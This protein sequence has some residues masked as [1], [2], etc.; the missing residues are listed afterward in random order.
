MICYVCSS[1]PLFLETKFGSI[2]QGTFCMCIMYWTY[3]LVT[4]CYVCACACAFVD[5]EKIQMSYFSISFS[6]SL[7][8]FFQLLFYYFGSTFPLSWRTMLLCAFWTDRSATILCIRKNEFKNDNSWLRNRRY[9]MALIWSEH[10][11]RNSLSLI[12][13]SSWR[14]R[15]RF[16]SRGQSFFILMISDS[17]S[18]SNSAYSWYNIRYLIS[19]NF[20]VFKEQIWTMW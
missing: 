13:V 6:L 17:D 8:L 10:L 11:L 4:W 18:D 20:P 15:V 12:W 19:G 16:F 7:F 3:L 5:K 14:I 2:M 9:R 1:I